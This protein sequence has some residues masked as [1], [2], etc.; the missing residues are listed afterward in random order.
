MTFIGKIV[1]SMGVCGFHLHLGLATCYAQFE[2]DST[3]PIEIVADSMEWLNEERIAIA[4]GNADA[5]QGRYTLSAHILTAHMANE[6]NGEEESN[7]QISLIEAEGNVLLITPNEKARGSVGIYD[8]RN[9][10]AI[11]TGNVVLTQGE[12]VL[13]GERLIMDLNTGHS[14]LDGATGPTELTEDGRVKAIF[15]PENVNEP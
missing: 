4:R 1:I 13:H 8:V 9:K 2:N 14:R 7:S 11:L 15:N 6:P 3:A 12:N 5:V 10:T